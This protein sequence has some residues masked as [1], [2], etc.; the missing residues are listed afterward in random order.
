LMDE[1]DVIGQISGAAMRF[2][3]AKRRLGPA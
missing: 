2:D 1:V 3:L